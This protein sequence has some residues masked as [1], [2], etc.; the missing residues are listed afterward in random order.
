M[1]QFFRTIIFKPL[2]NL[3]VHLIGILPG[4]SVGL[5]VILITILVKII[6]LPFNIKTVVSQI[7]LKK[8]QPELDAIKKENLDR[9]VQAQKTMALYKKYGVSP[10]SGCLPLLIQIP[11]IISLYY[12][13]F[14]GLTFDPELLYAGVSIPENV[15]TSFFGADL[16]GSSIVLAVLAGISQYFQIAIV[17]KRNPQPEGTGF[18]AQIGKSLQF[19]M[20][21]ILPVFI[22]FIAYRL[23]GAIALYWIVNNIVTIVMELIIVKKYQNKPLTLVVTQ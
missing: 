10:F 4:G 3:L 20:K 13:F 15:N 19:Q 9:T 22:V 14:Q 11:V 5:A 12:V 8:L 1:I 2:Y 17:N 18:Q 7:Q 23:S 16:G 6:L 21:Y